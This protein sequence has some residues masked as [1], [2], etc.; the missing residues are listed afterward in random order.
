M[1]FRNY[2]LKMQS[3][4]FLLLELLPLQEEPQPITCL[5]LP[6]HKLAS[7]PLYLHLFISSLL[8]LR[9][10]TQ[11][12]SNLSIPPFVLLAV[13]C[14]EFS[15]SAAVY[16]HHPKHCPPVG[17]G[18]WVQMAVCLSLWPQQWLCPVASGMDSSKPEEPCMQ[19]KLGIRASSILALCWIFR[20]F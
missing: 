8:F 12:S 15:R 18:V 11:Q 19:D 16:S 3:K 5:H 9:V 10:S 14:M 20:R 13:S 7:C 17:G 6:S 4:D 1:S 2:L